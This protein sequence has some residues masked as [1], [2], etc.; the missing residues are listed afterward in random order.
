MSRVWTAM[1]DQCGGLG[2]GSV[3]GVPRCPK[4]DGI[5]KIVIHEVKAWRDASLTFV[6]GIVFSL[7]VIYILHLAG[8]L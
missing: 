4:C 6:L 7:G 5:G 8:C 1:C 3:P 2:D